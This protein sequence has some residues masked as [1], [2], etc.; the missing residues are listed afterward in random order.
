MNKSIKGLREDQ[1]RIAEIS[2]VLSSLQIVSITRM[3][4][5]IYKKQLYAP[6]LEELDKLSNQLSQIKVNYKGEPTHIILSCDQKFCRKLL[7]MLESHVRSLNLDENSE[8][9]LFGKR[10]KKFLERLVPAGKIRYYRA[11]THLAECERIAFELCKTRPIYL[12]TYLDDKKTYSMVELLP[13]QTKETV[14]QPQD[15]KNLSSLLQ[16]YLAS[17][18]YKGVLETGI[19]EYTDR[20]LSMSEASENAERSSKELRII[21]NKTRQAIVTKEITSG[22]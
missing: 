19:K 6:V 10:S 3:R 21:Y 7:N 4:Q 8:V 5:F 9:I 18:I 14:I 16:L 2:G 12:H 1:A 17:Q 11:L 15:Q 13:I 20:A 22:D